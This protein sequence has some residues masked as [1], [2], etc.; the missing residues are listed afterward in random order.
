MGEKKDM[1]INNKPRSLINS[2]KVNSQTPTLR[3]TKLSN[4]LK[5]IE[6]T[7]KA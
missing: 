1:K 2:N 3:H 7:F 4:F 5:D 6:R